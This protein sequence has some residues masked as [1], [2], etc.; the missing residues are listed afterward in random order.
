[1]LMLMYVLSCASGISAECR[2]LSTLGCLGEDCITVECSGRALKPTLYNDQ[3]SACEISGESTMVLRVDADA[4]NQ[5]REGCNGVW[6]E[7]WF[8]E[9]CGGMDEGTS[10]VMVYCGIEERL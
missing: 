3:I 8:P 7:H 5:A 6:Y 10:Q 4:I 9:E 2:G 1:M